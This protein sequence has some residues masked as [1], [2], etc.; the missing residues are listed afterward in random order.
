MGA[1]KNRLI[2]TDVSPNLKLFANPPGPTSSDGSWSCQLVQSP[3]T[4]V[5]GDMAVSSCGSW[6]LT[7]G[8]DQALCLWQLVE[9]EEMGKRPRLL[10]KA[11]TQEAHNAHI[12]AVCFA[13]LVGLSRIFGFR[14][15]RPNFCNN[16]ALHL[17]F[18][19]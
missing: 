16:Y 18:E 9:P 14:T 2:L 10:S 15:T 1:A 19:Y 7:G 17:W 12:S 13:R 11:Y 6:L 4:G 8:H 3:H 5:I